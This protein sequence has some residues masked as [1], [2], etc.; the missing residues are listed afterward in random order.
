M[1]TWQ[2]N[3]PRFAAKG[4][5]GD[6]MTFFFGFTNLDDIEV[7]EF[8]FIIQLLPGDGTWSISTEW[9]QWGERAQKPNVEAFL[10]ELNRALRAHKEF[11][12]KKYWHAW[13]RED[14]YFSVVLRNTIA[15][16]QKVF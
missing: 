4:F 10:S 5:M 11:D 7:P 13:S 1:L 3:A 16:A 12:F 9:H 15:D 14:S 8:H 2:N 6:K